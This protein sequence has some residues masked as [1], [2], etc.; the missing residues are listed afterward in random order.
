MSFHS[1][2]NIESIRL[3]DM[4]VPGSERLGALP[5]VTQPAK[6]AAASDP[7]QEPL[8]PVGLLSKSIAD[9]QHDWKGPAELGRVTGRQGW[10][11]G[12]RLSC[13]EIGADFQGHALHLL[14]IPPSAVSF[15]SIVSP[16][17]CDGH[18]ITT[19]TMLR[20]EGLCSPR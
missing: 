1:G 4:R 19:N 16:K 2:P 7:S 3:L 5:R 12:T 17:R 6:G 20:K 8:R 13:W 14:L 11:R 18:P 15:Y 10:G 9:G